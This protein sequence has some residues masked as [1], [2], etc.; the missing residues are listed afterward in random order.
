MKEISPI[1]VKES[2]FIKARNFSFIREKEIN[3][4]IILMESIIIQ[5][6]Y[7]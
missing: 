2:R 6:H 7:T 3:Q 4:F 5:A 1:K